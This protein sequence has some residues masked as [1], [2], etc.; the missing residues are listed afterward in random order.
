MKAL[1]LIAT[2]VFCSFSMASEIEGQ[3]EWSRQ[4]GGWLC[5]AFNET[6]NTIFVNSVRFYGESRR[7]GE[8]FRLEA[9][10]KIVEPGEEFIFYR[11]VILPVDI[12]RGC[13]I[14]YEIN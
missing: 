2:F 7:G 12:A 11:R 13:I 6:E 3:V 1:T 4:G 14:S 9:V 10:K 5:K 8:A